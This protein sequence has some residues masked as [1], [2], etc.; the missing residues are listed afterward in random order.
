MKASSC[1]G[2]VASVML[3]SP[4]NSTQYPHDVLTLAALR[5]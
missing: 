5:A 1:C 4:K 2:L 3:A